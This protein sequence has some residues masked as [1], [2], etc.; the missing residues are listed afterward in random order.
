MRRIRTVQ[1]IDIF[2]QVGLMNQAPTGES[3]QKKN[4]MYI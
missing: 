2:K 3:I 4:Q 1:F